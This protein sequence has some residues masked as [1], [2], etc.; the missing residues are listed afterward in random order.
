MV[1]TGLGNGRFSSILLTFSRRSSPYKQ[2]T[3]TKIAHDP[4]PLGER[5]YQQSTTKEAPLFVF[6]NAAR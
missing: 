6:A 2:A 1:Q 5:R 3:W 4:L